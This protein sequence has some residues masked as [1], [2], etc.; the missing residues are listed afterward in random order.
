MRSFVR[1]EKVQEDLARM[2][3]GVSA[4]GLISFLQH[5]ILNYL[6]S[7]AADTIDSQHD[8]A[9][10]RWVPLKES[11]QRIRRN[12][13]G[14]GPDKPIN[15]RTGN[16]VEYL[17]AAPAQYTPTPEG[18]IMSFPGDA[19]RNS[20]RLMYAYHTAQGGSGRWGTP[21]RPVVGLGPTSY[22]AIDIFTNIYLQEL[23]G[24]DYGNMGRW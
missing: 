12:I 22:V 23:M 7:E 20:T 4:A 24:M 13:P 15:F 1:W 8:P 17:A 16:L 2:E 11:T 14:I 3:R 6:Q 9:G 5:V 18:A 10:G 21:A 19:S